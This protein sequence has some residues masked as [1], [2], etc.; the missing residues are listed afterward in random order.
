MMNTE[1]ITLKQQ[2]SFVRETKAKW[3]VKF[4]SM[5]NEKRMKPEVAQSKMNHIDAVEQTLERCVLLEEVSDE[6]KIATSNPQA[7]GLRHP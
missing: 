5:V 3:S 7:G 6:M 2:L 1:P 4:R